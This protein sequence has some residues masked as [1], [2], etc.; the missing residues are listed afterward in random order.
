MRQSHVIFTSI[1]S[2]FIESGSEKNK[3]PEG[4][5]PSGPDFELINE[6][7]AGTQATT[8]DMKQT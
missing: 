5:T 8:D 7:S 3:V 1:K 4:V 2:G 6:F